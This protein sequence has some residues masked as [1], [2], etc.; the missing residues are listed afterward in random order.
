VPGFFI[1]PIVSSSLFEQRE[2]RIV[3]IMTTPKEPPAHSLNPEEMAS[4]INTFT[5]DRRDNHEVRPV[6]LQPL[7]TFTPQRGRFDP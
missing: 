1:L 7:N 3:P 6:Y 5:T 2:G 4:V